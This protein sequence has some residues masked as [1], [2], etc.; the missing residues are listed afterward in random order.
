MTHQDTV[1]DFISRD[2]VG[3]FFVADRATEELG[4]NDIGRYT[5]RVFCFENEFHL[6]Y[7][8]ASISKMEQVVE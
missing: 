3:L 5:A 2:G 7:A 6:A 1:G 8:R 4:N